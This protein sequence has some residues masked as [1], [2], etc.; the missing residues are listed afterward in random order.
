M[1]GAIIPHVLPGIQRDRTA[2]WESTLPGMVVVTAIAL[3]LFEL[4]IRSTP[5]VHIFGP[6]SPGFATPGQA[7]QSGISLRIF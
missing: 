6:A 4:F 1:H 3:P 2:W 5:L 7:A